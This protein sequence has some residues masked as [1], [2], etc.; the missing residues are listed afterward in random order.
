MGT[1]PTASPAQKG[2]L[3]KGRLELHRGLKKAES[4]AAIQMRTGKIGFN[5][6]LYM[7]KVPGIMSPAC[8]YGW[9]KQDVKHILLFCPEYSEG[10]T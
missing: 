10:R 9:R 4:S 1:L 3:L 6:F 5:H 8:Q 7:R 2:D